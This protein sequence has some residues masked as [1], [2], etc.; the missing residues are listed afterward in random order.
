MFA[1]DSDFSVNWTWI[2]DLCSKFCGESAL[3]AQ[4][5]VHFAYNH[6]SLPIWDIPE[7]KFL[8][9]STISPENAYSIGGWWVHLSSAS[10]R[11]A[12]Q[13]GKLGRERQ[14]LKSIPKSHKA[15]NFNTFFFRFLCYGLDGICVMSRRRF[16]R[17]WKGA[18]KDGAKNNGTDDWEDIYAARRHGGT[19]VAPYYTELK[20][21]VVIHETS[22]KINKYVSYHCIQFQSRTSWR[23]T[24]WTD[25]IAAVCKLSV[26]ANEFYCIFSA[27][28][29]CALV[30]LF[31]FAFA[32]FNP[33][34]AIK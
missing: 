18:R 8:L 12:I 11:I 21:C 16:R 19:A 25:C 20:Q 28:I 22:G 10:K 32:K 24:S 27:V 23:S 30:L 17:R 26:Y 7:N 31:V 4:T 5:F 33:L 14:K 9:Y 29:C 34:A 1:W 2:F 6:N 15:G 3:H 13:R